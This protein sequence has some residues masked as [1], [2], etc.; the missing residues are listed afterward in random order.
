MDVEE[1]RIELKQR[2]SGFAER[3]QPV[4]QFL[5]WKWNL[6]NELS[7]PQVSHILDALVDLIE[8]IDED[9]RSSSSGGVEVFYIDPTPYD[10]CGYY[11][12]RFKFEDYVIWDQEGRSR[13]VSV[14]N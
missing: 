14:R 9:C 1:V 2:A 6:G 12:F 10:L 8:C 11:G 7:V 4:Y 5:G 3:I 13:F